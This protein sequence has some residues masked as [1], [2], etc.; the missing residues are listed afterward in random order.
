MDHK[1]IT[2]EPGEESDEAEQ[3]QTEMIHRANTETKTLFMGIESSVGQ[4]TNRTMDDMS[5]D[6][7]LNTDR[8]P[9]IADDNAEEGQE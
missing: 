4:D 5:V 1:L 6:E 9:L 3:E 8:L 2:N 7:R